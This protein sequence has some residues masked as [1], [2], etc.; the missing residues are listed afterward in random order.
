MALKGANATGKSTFVK[1]ILGDSNIIRSGNWYCP[2]LQNIGYLDQH[3]TNLDNQKSVLETIEALAP[4][5]S[6]EKT[7]CHLN[8]FLFR[9]NAEVFEKVECLSG[10]EKARLSLAQLAANPPHLLILD[11][12]T[13]NLDLETCM[14]VTQVLRNYPGAFILISHDAHFLKEVSITISYEIKNGEISAI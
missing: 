13:N 12:I 9:K 2:H 7:R 10:G 4:S 8:D 1:G 6:H 14:H 11:E 3:Y 5:W